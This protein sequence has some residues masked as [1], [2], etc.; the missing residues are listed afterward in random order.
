MARVKRGLQT[1]KRHKKILALAK[2]YKLGRNNL[3]RQAKQALLKAG[4]FAYRD[5][6]NKKRVFRRLWIVQL[7]AATRAHGLSYSQFIHGLE[8]S[9]LNLNRK[10]L[11]DLSVKSPEQFAAVAEKVKAALAAKAS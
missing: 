9:D 10:V 6:K 8:K 1:K 2:G 4:Q 11:A 5:R 3:F 7:N